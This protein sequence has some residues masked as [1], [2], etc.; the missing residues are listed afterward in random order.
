MTASVKR[1]AEESF[2]SSVARYKV[3]D[4]YIGTVSMIVTHPASLFPGRAS[5]AFLSVS[6]C[7]GRPSIGTN[8]TV[9]PWASI[10]KANAF[11]G[12]R[13]LTTDA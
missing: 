7:H 2:L 1:A 6:L 13:P 9:K 11:G 4:L 8:V 3:N 5:I 10:A 12:D